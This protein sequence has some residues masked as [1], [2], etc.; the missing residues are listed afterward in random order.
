MKKNN[1]SLQFNE[2]IFR[3][4]LVFLFLLAISTLVA[5]GS[6][7]ASHGD[8]DEGFSE[9]AEENNESGQESNEQVGEEDRENADLEEEQPEG[10]EVSDFDAL[11]EP[12][13]A[14]NLEELEL[15]FPNGDRCANPQRKFSRWILEFPRMFASGS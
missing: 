1:L 11:D 9:V 7:S 15:L 6:P 3:S 10:V 4:S 13:E 12:N 2:G 5:C 14:D 8:S